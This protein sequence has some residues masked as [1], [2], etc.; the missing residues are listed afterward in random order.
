MGSEIGRLK[1]PRDEL[2]GAKTNGALEDNDM[3]R[4]EQIVRVDMA[5]YLYIEKNTVLNH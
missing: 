5:L 2:P 3:K 4:N 1:H